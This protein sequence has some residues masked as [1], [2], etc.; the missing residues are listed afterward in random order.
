MFVISLS[1]MYVCEDG[2]AVPGSPLRTWNTLEEAIAA[3]IELNATHG[4]NAYIHPADR[5]D[6]T[7]EMINTHSF[8]YAN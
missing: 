7:V 6:H 2:L 8:G 5:R 1:N 3:A 4:L